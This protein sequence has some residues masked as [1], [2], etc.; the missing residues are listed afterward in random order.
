MGT[1]VAQPLPIEGEEF[2]VVKLWAWVGVFWLLVMT[3]TL[4][5]WIATGNA[6]PVDPGADIPAF[7][8]TRWIITLDILGPII[9]GWVFWRYII[10]PKIRTGKL[11]SDGILL[12]VFLFMFWQ[13]SMLVYSSPWF[14]YNGLHFNL[15][16]WVEFAPGALSPNTRFLGE[17]LLTWTTGYIFFMMWPIVFVC[18]C[19]RKWKEHK[20][21]AGII[22]LICV[23]L[24]AGFSFDLIMEAVYLHTGGYAYAGSIQSISLFGGE[25]WHFPLYEIV[26]WGGTYAVCGCWRYFKDDKG[27]MMCEKGIDKLQT[28]DGSKTFIRFLAISGLMQ[29]TMMITY[30]LPMQWFSTHGDAMP[31]GY[32]SYLTSGICG[33]GTRYA[34]PAPSIPITRTIEGISVD[35][36]LELRYGTLPAEKILIRDITN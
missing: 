6:T 31:E 17:P 24:A 8:T 3:Y 25:M 11:S 15:G 2:P 16:N 9:A 27:H 5:T 4:G 21:A 1:S 12:L 29:T 22:S 10:N 32:P 33:E 7:E 19:M 26:A 18:W 23:A 14:F 35:P 20:P 28:G 34:C 30:N 36:N 13:D